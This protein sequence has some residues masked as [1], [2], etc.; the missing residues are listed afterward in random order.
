MRTFLLAVAAFF[1]FLV[2]HLM[3]GWVL[4]TSLGRTELPA[5]RV[6]VERVQYPYTRSD[7]GYHPPYPPPRGYYGRAAPYYP[8]RAYGRPVW[9]TDRWEFTCDAEIDD[10]ERLPIRIAP[11][12]SHILGWVPNNA[13]GISAGHVIIQRHCLQ[14]TRRGCLEWQEIPWRPVWFRSIRGFVGDAYLDCESS[15]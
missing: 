15:R 1:F 14:P 2:N 7:R 9:P 3:S 4:A 12:Q 8:R 11:R 5:E 10:D 13:E 6:A